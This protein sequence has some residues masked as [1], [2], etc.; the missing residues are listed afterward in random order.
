M[1]LFEEQQRFNQWWLYAILLLPFGF[2][3]YELINIEVNWL[4][5]LVEIAIT[6]L[7][8]GV[9]FSIQLKTKINTDGIVI[10]FFPFL[11]KQKM[12]P[13]SVIKNAEV[14]QYSPIG[15]YGGWG[16]RKSFKNGEAYNI[17]GNQG[18][19]LTFENGKKLLIGTQKPKELKSVIENIKSSKG[20]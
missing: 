4:N 2:L 18:L 13:W 9:L 3:V 19:Q 12:I 7:I 1:V 16:W 14:R 8:L 17:R 5:F 6:I 15:E 11:R 20:S 10:R